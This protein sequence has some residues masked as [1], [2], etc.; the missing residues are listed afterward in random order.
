M[1]WYLPR[2]ILIIDNNQ[3]NQN[4]Y[5]VEE[6]ISYQWPPIQIYYSSR[7][8]PTTWY[9]KHYVKDGRTNHS[10]YSC[11]TSNVIIDCIRTHLF[12]SFFKSYIG[13]ISLLVEVLLLNVIFTYFYCLKRVEKRLLT[14]I[15]IL[16]SYRFFQL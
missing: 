1:R 13:E 11:E 8:Q 9:D 4:W 5:S 6:T 2:Y 16:V 3:H 12:I 7:T 15:G 10:R 14:L